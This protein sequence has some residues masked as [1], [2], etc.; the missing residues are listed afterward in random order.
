MCGICRKEKTRKETKRKGRSV[1]M[2][3]RK[4]VM[5]SVRVIPFVEEK[6]WNE[7]EEGKEG[8]LMRKERRKGEKG[9][10]RGKGKKRREKETTKRQQEE[11]MN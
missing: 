5:W 9:I 11:K 6:E 2:E 3:E 8:R 1:L 4:R 10:K 7:K